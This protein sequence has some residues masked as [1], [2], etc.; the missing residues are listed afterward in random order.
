MRLSK[1]IVVCLIVLLGACASCSSQT[2]NSSSMVQLQAPEKITGAPTVP[3]KISLTGNQEGELTVLDLTVDVHSQLPFEP[4]I[5]FSLPEGAT[6]VAGD[7]SLRFSG[8]RMPG[9]VSSRHEFRNVQ[10]P[11]V[12][13]A[14]I[15]TESFGL[16]AE[17]QWPPKAPTEVTHPA[18]VEIPKVKIGGVEID[19]AIPLD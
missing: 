11:V 6:T 19:H 12:V 17:A 16:H 15:L 2:K 10:G 1:P 8:S 9:K 13:T 18:E 4:V 3:L 14:D 5:R 7:H